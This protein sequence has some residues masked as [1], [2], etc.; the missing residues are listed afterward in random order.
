MRAG[1]AASV[2][3][4]LQ[5]AVEPL[6]RAQLNDIGM[7]L[8]E[9][10]LEAR[11]DSRREFL[12]LFEPAFRAQGDAEVRLTEQGVGVLGAEHPGE[13]RYCAAL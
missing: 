10:P 4:R 9:H 3:L 12:G 6:A 5:V 2:V 13:L 7:I 8:A 11:Q 1:E